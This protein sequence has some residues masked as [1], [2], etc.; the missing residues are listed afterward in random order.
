MLALVLVNPY[1]DLTRT[2]SW[3]TTQASTGSYC[4]GLPD[5]WET[6]VQMWHTFRAVICWVIWKESNNQVFS[7]EVFSTHRAVGLAWH[8]LGIYIKAVWYDHLS[9]VHLHRFTLAKARARM[10]TF[11]GP[12]GRIWTLHVIKVQVSLVPPRPP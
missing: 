5:E 3:H 10:I 1:V 4:G 9:K 12:E 6:P 11:F 7:G 2:T 8:R